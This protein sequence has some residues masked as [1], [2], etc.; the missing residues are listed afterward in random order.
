MVYLMSDQQYSYSLAGNKTRLTW[1]DSSAIDYGYS[2]HGELQTVTIPGEGAISVSEY[3]W[4][5]PKKT[6]L[7]GGGIQNRSFDG[8]LN[9]ENLN[10]KTPSQQTTLN[11]DNRFGKLQ[12]LNNRSRTD[13]GNN[14][15]T[16]KT[17]QFSFD[18]DN[19]L[20]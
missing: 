11:L 13:A 1:P 9:L 2:V 18:A 3:A 17:E 10:T 20:T 4:N 12:E 8:L 15:S 19:R 16:S 7:P 5:A 6:L 14:L